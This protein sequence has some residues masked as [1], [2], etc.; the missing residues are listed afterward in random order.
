[1]SNCEFIKTLPVANGLGESV[2]WH[3]ESQQLLW[4]DMPGDQLLRYTPRTGLIE[5]IPTPE[6][7]CS[8]GFIHNSQWLLCAFQSGIARFHPDS[9]ALQ[10][11]YRLPK[12]HPVRL[13]DGRVDRQGR[14]WV[15][16]LIDSLGNTCDEPAGQGKLYRVDHDGSVTEHLGGIRISN[17]LCW[18]PNGNIMYFADSPTSQIDQFD[19]CTQTGT[20]TNKRCFARTQGGIN[21]DGAI[22]D[23][24]GHLWSAQWGNGKVIRY[25]P[26][27]D[28][29]TVLQLPV[30]QVTCLTFGGKDLKQLYIT[31]A[32]FGLSDEELAAQPEAGNVFIYQTNVQGLR[33]M[34]FVD[35]HQS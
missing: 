15:G 23:A 12:N 14:F 29:D 28:I 31:T 16:S 34:A 9:R 8:F 5:R 2:L 21:P 32:N 35:R 27:G 26:A 30:S 24:E 4:T 13:N 22:V 25:T 10:W 17:S 6:N 20:I 7:L 1:M 18:S 11:L 19:F 33:E 3:A